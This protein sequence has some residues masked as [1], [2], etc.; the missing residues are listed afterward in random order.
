MALI[1]LYLTIA[2]SIIFIVVGIMWLRRFQGE[3][4]QLS[5]REYALFLGLS[6]IP[7]S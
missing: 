7:F 1:F 3:K 4:Q 2:L 5:R 6:P